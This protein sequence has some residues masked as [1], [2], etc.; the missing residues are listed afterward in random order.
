MDML[1]KLMMDIDHVF[2]TSPDM[3]NDN[4]PKKENEQD[5]LIEQLIATGRKK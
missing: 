2:N 1:Q 5:E 3:M 4:A